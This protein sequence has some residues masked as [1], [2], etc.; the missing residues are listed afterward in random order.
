MSASEVWVSSE[1]VGAP[2]WEVP[3]GAK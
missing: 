1:G 3:V 2:L